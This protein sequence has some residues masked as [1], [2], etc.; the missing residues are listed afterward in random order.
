MTNT[1]SV[2]KRYEVKYTLTTAQYLQLKATMAAHMSLDSYGR[3]TIDTMYFDT[4]DYR[5]IRRSIEK[6]CYKEKLR[7]R[8]Y[9]ATTD[10]DTVYLELKKKYDGVVYKRRLALPKAEAMAFL[11]QDKP[12][13][14]NSQIAKELTYFCEFYGNLKP[15]VG[16]RYEREAFFGNQDKGFRITFDHAITMASQNRYDTPL[17]DSDTV[18]LEVKTA[19]GMPSWLT[20]FFSSHEIYKTSFSKVGTAYQTILLPKSLSKPTPKSLGGTKHVA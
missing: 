20:D 18:V 15:M 6:P 12:L 17:L 4:P 14:S 16:L 8:S 3:H 7:L 11:T 9:G 13:T 10:T 5:L 19:L 2:F 1:P